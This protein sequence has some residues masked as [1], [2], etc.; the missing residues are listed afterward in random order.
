MAGS[1]NT[2]FDVGRGRPLFTPR[3]AYHRTPGSAIPDDDVVGIGAV[4]DDGGSAGGGGSAVRGGPTDDRFGSRGG[5]VREI[6]PG[7]STRSGGVGNGSGHDGGGASSGGGEPYRLSTINST[8]GINDD[9]SP[10]FLSRSSVNMS[11]AMSTGSDEELEGEEGA[12]S[13]RDVR[14]DHGDR[15]DD[16]DGDAGVHGRGETFSDTLSP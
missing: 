2:S 6:N 15:A 4:M 16:D 5:A 7:V 3:S 1:S 8:S 10:S 9:Q 13:G 12:G 11:V 14:L